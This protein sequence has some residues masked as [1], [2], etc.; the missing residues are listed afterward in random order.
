MMN[1]EPNWYP[2]AAGIPDFP[3]ALP[4]ELAVALGSLWLAI[5]LLSLAGIVWAMM[6]DSR[7]RPL[8]KSEKGAPHRQHSGRARRPELYPV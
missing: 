6:R 7:Q 5:S 3:M 8:G 4:P 1:L 2:P